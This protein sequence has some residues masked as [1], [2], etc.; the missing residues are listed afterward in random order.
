MIKLRRLKVVK[1]R[2]VVPGT[3]LRFDD[4]INL[5]HGDRATGKTTLLTLLSMVCRGS[6]AVEAADE[7][8]DIE[9]ELASRVSSPV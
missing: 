9:A 1:F 7:P 5:V 4:G 8:L 2:H 3:E 6:F